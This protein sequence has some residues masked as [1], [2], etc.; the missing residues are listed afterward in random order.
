MGQG[1]AAADSSPGRWLRSR[2]FIAGA[3]SSMGFLILDQARRMGDLEKENAWLK[4][5]VADL[6]G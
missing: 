2:L 1:K 5:L 3:K 4:R 6:A